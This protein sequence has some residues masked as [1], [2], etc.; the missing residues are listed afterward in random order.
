MRLTDNSHIGILKNKYYLISMTAE[1]WN[2]MNIN[3][4]INEKN[5]NI[6]FGV[7][8]FYSYEKN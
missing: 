6:V 2:Y 8:K 7:Y 4:T 5:I 3:F 1:P